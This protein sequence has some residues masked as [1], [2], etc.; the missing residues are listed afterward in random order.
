VLGFDTLLIQLNATWSFSWLFAIFFGEI[1]ETGGLCFFPKSAFFGLSNDMWFAVLPSKWRAYEFFP[2][3]HP[4]RSGVT[5]NTGNDYIRTLA[6]GKP[7]VISHWSPR[8]PL[9]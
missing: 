2:Q 6:L 5:L 3:G 9:Q 8:F 4:Q 7:S 1:E